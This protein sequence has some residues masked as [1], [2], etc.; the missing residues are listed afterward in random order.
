[1]NE[2]TLA[3]LKASIVKWD[4]NAEAQSPEDA[5]IFAHSCPLCKLFYKNNCAECPVRDRTGYIHCHE[6]PWE[7]AASELRLWIL[8]QE[9]RDDF[10]AAAK[11][12]ADFLRSLLPEDKA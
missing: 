7:D 9:N 2:E 10:R 6:S 3:A 4:K 8:G 5:L 1:M 12:E 11:Q